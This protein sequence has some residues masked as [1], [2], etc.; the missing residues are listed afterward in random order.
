MTA[1]ANGFG[2]AWPGP[3]RQGDTRG[4]KGG[5]DGE[6]ART[7][8]RAAHR[9][10]AAVGDPF[11]PAM[12]VVGVE[13]GRPPLLASAPR[14]SFQKLEQR[15]CHVAELDEAT[16]ELISNVRGHIARPSLCRIESNDA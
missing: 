14:R 11:R 4:D 2:G 1:A 9:K 15:W 13:K 10:T 6:T 16:A 3:C 12:P 7:H 8:S 5:I